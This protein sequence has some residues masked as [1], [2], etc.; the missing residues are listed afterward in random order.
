MDIVSLSYEELQQI[1]RKYFSLSNLGGDI[2]HKFALI[3]LVCWLTNKI[4]ESK[5]DWNHWKTLYK[6]NNGTLPEDFIKGLSIVCS[7]FG[8][9]CT[10]FPTFG[11]EEK[12]IPAKIKEILA[13]WLPF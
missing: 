8:Y 2:N 3:S 5:P 4:K 9:C 12:K 6:I 10:N 13:E 7:D 1:Y 11:I